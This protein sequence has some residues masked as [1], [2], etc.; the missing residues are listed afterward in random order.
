MPASLNSNQILRLMSER[1]PSVPASGS[2]TQKVSS[3]SMPSAPNS[4]RIAAGA[5]SCSTRDCAFAASSMICSARSM[6]VSYETR[7]RVTAL[8]FLSP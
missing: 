5:G 4:R 8:P 6:S 7:M 3:S 1:V 2:G